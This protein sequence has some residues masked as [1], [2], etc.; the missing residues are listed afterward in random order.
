MDPTKTVLD[1]ALAGSAVTAPVWLAYVQTGFGL[2]ASIGGVVLLALRIWAVWKE[3]Q[4]KAADK[5]DR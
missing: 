4:A 5:A 1:T 2:V 3:L